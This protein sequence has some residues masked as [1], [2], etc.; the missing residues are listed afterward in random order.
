MYER[1]MCRLLAFFFLR[2]RRLVIE[3][4]IVINYNLNE[5]ILNFN[6]FCQFKLTIIQCNER[7]SL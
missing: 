2:L 5:T 6:G 4:K 3:K 1:R 7:T